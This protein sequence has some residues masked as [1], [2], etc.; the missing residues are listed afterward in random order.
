MTDVSTVSEDVFVDEEDDV[1]VL[2]EPRFKY[3]RILGHLVKVF[4]LFML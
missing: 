1:E 2:V 3:S 4:S